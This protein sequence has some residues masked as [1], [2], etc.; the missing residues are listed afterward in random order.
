[1]KNNLKLKKTKKIFIIVSILIGLA[2]ILGGVTAYI[3]FSEKHTYKPSAGKPLVNPT[4][5]LSL[6]EAIKKFDDK[7][8]YYLLVS[9]KAYDLHN[10]PFSSNIPKIEIYVDKDI[11]YGKISE[12]KITV[13]KGNIENPDITIRTTKEEAVKM[14]QNKNYIADSFK[15]GLSSIELNAGKLELASKGYLNLYNQFSA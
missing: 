14:I 3:L 15:N 6:E 12:G 4:Q 11:Y 13:G 5:G 2:L 10:P 7:F 1:M 9:I 8:I